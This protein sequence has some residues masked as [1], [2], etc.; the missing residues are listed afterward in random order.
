M[1]TSYSGG[2]SGDSVVGDEQRGEAGER[3]QVVQLHDLV[4]TQVDGV[5]LVLRRAQVLDDGDLVPS[6]I[7][8]SVLDRV[9]E[10]RALPYQLRA[11]SNHLHRFPSF[12]PLRAP[13]YIRTFSNDTPFPFNCLRQQISTTTIKSQWNKCLKQKDKSMLYIR[14]IYICRLLLA[15]YSLFFFGQ[16]CVM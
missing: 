9:E 7:Q 12:R 10:V 3:R 5:E 15:D 1:S 16:L 11:D 14:L 6:E 2:D 4:V 8:L 13:L